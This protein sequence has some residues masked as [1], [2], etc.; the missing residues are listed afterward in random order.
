MLRKE[1]VTLEKEKEQFKELMEKEKVKLK[2]SEQKFKAE[3]SEKN[4]TFLERE[5]SIRKH[6]EKLLKLA[7]QLAELAEQNSDKEGRLRCADFD[8]LKRREVEEKE[9]ARIALEKLEISKER[10]ADAE[11]FQKENEILANA[12]REENQQR[13]EIELFS[14][15]VDDKNESLL[16]SREEY[17]VELTLRRVKNILVT[18]KEKRKTAARKSLKKAKEIRNKKA[19]EIVTGDHESPV[20]WTMERAFFLVTLPWKAG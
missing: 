20:L 5:L 13:N 3:V 17:L 6:E 14:S 7:E 18:E 8:S 10:E 11:R 12:V 9:E 2:E 15:A 4:K 16:T 19:R 1:R